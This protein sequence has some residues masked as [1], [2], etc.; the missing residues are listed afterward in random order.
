MAYDRF[1]LLQSSSR[2]GRGER[3]ESVH[4]AHKRGLNTK[5][6]AAVDKNGLPVGFICTKGTIA[7]CKLALPLLEKFNG[8][9]IATLFADKGYDSNAI[10]NR[11]LANG[12]EVVI[13]PKK[14]RREKREFNEEL[15]RERHLIENHFLDLKRWRGI[16]TRYSKTTAGFEAAVIVRCIKI[17]LDFRTKSR[18]DSA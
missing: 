18:V 1:D 17:W 12:M 10:V 9:N 16:S 5:I 11:A 15:Y 7:D 2:R 13:P 14:N 3:R 4:V 8:E 6:H